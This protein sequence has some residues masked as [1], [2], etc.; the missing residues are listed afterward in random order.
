MPNI[1]KAGS[2]D[3]VMQ[4]LAWCRRQNFKA[5]PLHPAQKSAIFRD[6]VK[7]GYKTPPDETWRSND[8]GIGIVTGPAASG[9]VDFD[10]DCPEAVFFANRFLPATSA[11]FGRASKRRSHYLYRT[12]VAE[13]EKRAYIDPADNSTIVEARGDGGHQ[14]CAPGSIHEGSG[15]PVE[16]DDVAFPDVPTV[17]AEA[18]GRAA[19]KVAIAT[20]IVRHIWAPG[21]H[22]EPAKHLTGLLFYLDWTE[23][24]VVEIIEA[25]MEYSEDD[26]KS[27]I[28]T[29]RATFRRG[30]AGK[31]ISGAGVLRKQLNNDAVVDR[32]LEWAGSVTVNLLQE[33]NDRYATVAVEGKFRIAATTRA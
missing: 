1:A 4:T 10:L 13:F 2:S 17:S 29:V 31:K 7:P 8:Y 32:L 16:W 12:D 27:R 14:T 22:N 6:Y 5:V 25:V 20:L 9:P 18:L 15:E 30:A 3:A 24:E 19:R 21:Y 23:D 33:Y 28:P 11:V 26:D